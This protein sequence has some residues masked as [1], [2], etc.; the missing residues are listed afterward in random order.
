MKKENIIKTVYYYQKARTAC[1]N[2]RQ[3]IR[4][5]NIVLLSSECDK[6][7]LKSVEYYYKTHAYSNYFYRLE[8]VNM[9]F[10]ESIHEGLKNILK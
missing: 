8:R 3:Y 1:F 6:N 5:E 9:G 2:V 7:G 10:I 4:K